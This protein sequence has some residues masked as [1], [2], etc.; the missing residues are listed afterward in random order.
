MDNQLSCTHTD[1]EVSKQFKKKYSPGSKS[2]YGFPIKCT[3]ICKACGI[4]IR[5]WIPVD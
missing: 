2:K 5:T 4:K 1:I 3:D